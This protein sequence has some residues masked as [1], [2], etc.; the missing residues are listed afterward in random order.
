MEGDVVKIPLC[1]GQLVLWS[2]RVAAARAAGKM[3]VVVM[4]DNAFG[5]R[6]LLDQCE[7]QELEG[8]GGIAHATSV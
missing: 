1:G 2:G 6:K 7:N 3:P 8:P 5:F 4:A